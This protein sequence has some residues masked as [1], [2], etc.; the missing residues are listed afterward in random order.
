MNF[1]LDEVRVGMDEEDL[2]VVKEALKIEEHILSHK[3]EGK[4]KNQ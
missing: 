2:E 4:M 1:F 3:N